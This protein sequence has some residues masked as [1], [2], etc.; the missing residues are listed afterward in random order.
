[1]NLGST[2]AGKYLNHH[3]P[4]IYQW[5]WLTYLPQAGVT[6]AIAA[7]VE[8]VFKDSWG[9]DFNAVAVTVVLFFEVLGPIALKFG[10]FKSGSLD[11]YN[12]IVSMD[13]SSHRSFSDFL[14]YS[15][16]HHGT[17]PFDQ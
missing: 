15:T 8:A 11:G 5:L 2:I 3:S 4:E 12:Q 7:E 6:L 10:L 17:L 13:V 9:S 16:S 1:M 14:K